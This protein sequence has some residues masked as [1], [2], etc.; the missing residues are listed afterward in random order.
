VRSLVRDRRGSAY[1]FVMI[2]A[3]LFVVTLI[4]VCFY[5]AIDYIFDYVDNSTIVPD[6]G[7]QTI[8]ILRVVW[9]KWPLVFVT[10]LVLLAIVWSQKREPQ[11]GWY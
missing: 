10:G 8:A 3:S 5:S 6:S 1:A 11:S 7:K 4:Y 2:M 9:D